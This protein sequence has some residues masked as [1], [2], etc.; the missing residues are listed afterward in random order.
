M[1]GGNS[2]P[3]L[4]HSRFDPSHYP[5][6]E[7]HGEPPDRDRHQI[8]K[9]GASVPHDSHTPF[10]FCK[11][12]A[13]TSAHRLRCRDS[14]VYSSARANPVGGRIFLF[15]LRHSF[16]NSSD[17]LSSWP[18]LNGRVVGAWNDS[19]S[20]RLPSRICHLTNHS[21]V[22]VG[23]FGDI[24]ETMLSNSW[25]LLSC[26]PNSVRIRFQPSTLC[27]TLSVYEFLDSLYFI[28]VFSMQ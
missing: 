22:E 12:Q 14:N 17:S 25:G 7:L 24:T 16:S 11:T 28:V 5:P 23:W 10:A 2:A 26:L 13:F 8:L 27:T 21:G 6:I 18:S 1:R 15:V 20:I 9:N 19:S 4:R 3:R